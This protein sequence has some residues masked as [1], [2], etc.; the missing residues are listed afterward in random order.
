VTRSIDQGVVYEDSLPPPFRGDTSA[1]RIEYPPTASVSAVRIVLAFFAILLVLFS[2][3]GAIRNVHRR[4]GTE[5]RPASASL[6]GPVPVSR[7]F[8][9]LFLPPPK[10]LCN[11]SQLHEKKL[12]WDRQTKTGGTRG[13]CGFESENRADVNLLR[14]LFPLFPVVQQDR[15]SFPPNY[16]ER[17]RVGFQMRVFTV[18]AGLG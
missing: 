8:R 2:A 16:P 17:A 12:K 5:T 11:C 13:W 15:F 1:H 6:I 10:P 3:A 9:R 7:R 14:S 18:R 4:G